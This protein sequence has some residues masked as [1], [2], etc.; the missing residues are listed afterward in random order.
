MKKDGQVISIVAF[1]AITL[2]V[3]VVAFLLVSFTNTILSPVGTQLGNMS[4]TAGT[5][6][7]SVSD[8]FNTWFDVFIIVLFFLNVII[9]M[10][11]A[12]MVDVHPL[13]L[14]V[15][16][17]S[18]FLLM[19]FGGN[20]MS[21]INILW[22]DTGSFSNAIEHMP[23]T[24]WMLDHFTLVILSIIIISGIVMYSKFRYGSSGGEF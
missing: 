1:F 3:F 24:V 21:S 2:S 14:I 22:S 9:L 23:L 20:M 13:F 15:Y 19:M 8:S 7:T 18:A 17:M 5:A 10:I 11:S 16:V 4:D 6:V 12:F